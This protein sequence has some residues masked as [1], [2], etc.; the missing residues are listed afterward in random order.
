MINILWSWLYFI[1]LV[2]TICLPTFLLFKSKH[3][4]NGNL[5]TITKAFVVGFFQFF[6]IGLLLFYCRVP[7]NLNGWLIVYLVH[8][9]F[10]LFIW[11]QAKQRELKSQVQEKVSYFLYF[12]FV[13]LLLMF[14]FWQTIRQTQIYGDSCFYWFAKGWTFYNT[15]DIHSFPYLHAPSY[16]L[17]IPLIYNFFLQM[18]CGLGIAAYTAMLLIATILITLQ[19]GW[20]KAG[21]LSVIIGL[22]WALFLPLFFNPHILKSYADIPLA[23]VYYLALLMI[24]ETMFAAKP[25]YGAIVLSA[26]MPLIKD[27]GSYLLLPVIVISLYYRYGKDKKWNIHESAALFGIPLMVFVSN[28]VTMTM[29]GVKTRIAEIYIPVMMQEVMNTSNPFLAYWQKLVPS[30]R[31]FMGI[32]SDNPHWYIILLPLIALLMFTRFSAPY[33]Y[34]LVNVV[35]TLV[36]TVGF[37]YVFLPSADRQ[38]WFRTGYD[39]ALFLIG[40]ASAGLAYLACTKFMADCWNRKTT[41]FGTPNIVHDRQV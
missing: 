31:Y 25:S 30:V 39:R 3:F 40:P 12:G 32:A 18:D 16:P 23:L 5:E 14:Y 4:Y 1:L 37:V 41:Y 10:S 15:Q 6:M 8:I 20:D 24:A 7:I 9:L 11:K 17:L 19:A 35:V 36:I 13:C 29:A 28:G 38:S 21:K 27:N 2:L 33:R 26:A 22:P 34:I